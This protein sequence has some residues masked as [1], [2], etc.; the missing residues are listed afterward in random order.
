MNP[1]IQLLLSVRS[2]GLL[3]CTPVYS[4]FAPR[5]LLLHQGFI[6]VDLCYV[7][8]RNEKIILALL[9]SINFTHILD[10]MI[11]MPLG[12]YLMPY[13]NISPQQ[14]SLLVAA[15]TLSAGISGL[16]QLFL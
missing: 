12:N 2:S 14:F 15:Y 3:K 6:C 4:F 8:N 16:L 5:D 1:I 11:M 7:M 10:F 9:A 13:F